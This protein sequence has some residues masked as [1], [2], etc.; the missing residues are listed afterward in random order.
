MPATTDLALTRSERRREYLQGCRESC[1]VCSCVCL[2][3]VLMVAAVV[4]LGI[5]LVYEY[6]AGFSP[7]DCFRIAP[8]CNILTVEHSYNTSDQSCTD[9]FTYA[10]AFSNSPVVYME[11]ENR[12]R[13][14]ADCQA[15]L[16]ISKANATFQNGTTNC[17]IIRDEYIEYAK[18][19]SCAP[20]SQ[21]NN[22]SV[23]RCTTLFSPRSSYDSTLTV[24][25][26]IIL[27][28]LLGSN[29]LFCYDT[30]DG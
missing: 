27:L 5:W 25:S 13:Q 19:F 4:L 14:L 30:D 26:A 23:G 15:D 22:G 24:A 29:G 21:L 9:T 18:Y 28:V 20:V 7:E 17:F 8:L 1:T 2:P 6:N 16:D 11:T 3:F 10:W 12:K